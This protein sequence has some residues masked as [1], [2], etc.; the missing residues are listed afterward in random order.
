MLLGK[1]VF[2]SDKIKKPKIKLKKPP[3]IV[4]VTLLT[5]VFFCSRFVFKFNSTF[6]NK[7][8]WNELVRSNFRIVF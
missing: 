3:T 1:L 4:K 7:N 6:N 2:I 5:N 8:A